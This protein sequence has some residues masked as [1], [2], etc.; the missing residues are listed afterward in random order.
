MGL[1][2]CSQRDLRVKIFVG[3]IVHK[4]EVRVVRLEIRSH[5]RFGHAAVFF[6]LPSFSQF[7]Q[8]NVIRL[9]RTRLF[10]LYNY[11]N[12]CCFLCIKILKMD[13]RLVD[14]CGPVGHLPPRRDADAHDR[15][16]L[17]VDAVVAHRLSHMLHNSHVVSASHYP[18]TWESIVY[19][20]LLRP[21]LQHTCTRDREKRA[22]KKTDAFRYLS[23]H[24]H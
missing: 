18:C 11:L 23:V 5:V 21:T 16:A 17:A 14:E 4:Q 1:E 22:K 12:Y 7:F 10:V 2:F 15:R 3:A 9:H 19:T 13:S 20:T 6:L 8:R 24:L